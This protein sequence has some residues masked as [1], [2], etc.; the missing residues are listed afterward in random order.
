M[1]PANDPSKETTQKQPIVP[2]DISYSKFEAVQR[3]TLSALCTGN[4]AE[5]Q[6]EVCVCVCVCE[7][8]CVCVKVE[9][10]M[11]I[12]HKQKWVHTDDW[13]QT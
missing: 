6:P 10:V 5:S 7:C 2:G 13:S 12:C 1:F 4:E 9:L 3:G 11:K 8:M